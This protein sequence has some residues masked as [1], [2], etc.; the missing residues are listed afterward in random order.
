MRNELVAKLPPHLGRYIFEFI[1]FTQVYAADEPSGPYLYLESGT[2]YL[3]RY[4]LVSDACGSSTCKSD[5][6]YDYHLKKVSVGKDLSRA[7]LELYLWKCRRQQLRRCEDAQEI[8]VES[9]L[10]LID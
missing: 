8:P 7:R 5:R 6:G 1:T 10:A 9:Y 2:Y 4:I 3:C